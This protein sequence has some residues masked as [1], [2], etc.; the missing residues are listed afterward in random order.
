MIPSARRAAL[1][2]RLLAWYDAER[3]ELPWRFAQLG[4]DPYRVWV[5]EVMLQQTQV[6]AAI[7]YYHRFLARFPT[8]EVLAAAREEDVFAQ[9][10]GLGYY[11]RA[12]NLHA[13]ARE[14]LRE[15][16]GLPRSL[17]A[18]RALPGF[19]PYTAGAVAS[20]AFAI[21]A[22]AVDGN[23]ARVL[24]R[25]FLVRGDPGHGP[26]RARV[27]DLARALV[28]PER[29]GDLNQALMDLGATVC[30]KPVP[31]CG[32]CPVTALCAARRAGLERVV[33]PARRRP[34]R[35]PLVLGCAVVRRGDAILVARQPAR[36]LFAGLWALP[37]AEL[38]PDDDARR[39]LARALRGEHDLRAAVREEL[40]TCERTLTH[41]ALTLRAFRCELR[42]PLHETTRLR[43][44][45][46]RAL[47]G[48]AVP[49]AARALLV[50]VADVW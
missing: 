41:R 4:A 12:R 49:A 40:A 6:R 28:D 20:I 36:G 48:L 21:P 9:W 11:A 42:A 44:A 17:E 25:L 18:L 19:G 27:D 31:G 8:L 1:R 14:A 32:R 45:S 7:P 5:A 47:R 3:R 30:G 26:V 10:S 37:S 2:R 16:G 22:A 24:A 29:P 39:T 46:P 13:A 43:F 34:A 33:P 23:V 15:H 50:R 38:R 35:R